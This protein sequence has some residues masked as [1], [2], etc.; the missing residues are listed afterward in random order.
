MQHYH[1]ELSLKAKVVAGAL[2]IGA[3]VGLAAWVDRDASNKID[4]NTYRM[5]AT[6][7]AEYQAFK[8]F[9]KNEYT[10][11]GPGASGIIGSEVR[12]T[13]D[14]GNPGA[15]YIVQP[16]ELRYI[17]RGG[18]FFAPREITEKRDERFVII[19]GSDIANVGDRIEFEPGIK[20][21]FKDR[22]IGSGTKKFTVNVGTGSE[23]FDEPLV[24]PRYF[25]KVDN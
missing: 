13:F 5:R 6:V 17:T 15:A 20:Q 8:K 24:N 7:V 23:V 12:K 1:E 16:E 11:K 9:G 21:R 4:P 14:I 18:V 10:T 19:S 22:F 25:K 3:L 2:G